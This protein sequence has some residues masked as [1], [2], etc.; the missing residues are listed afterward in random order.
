MKHVTRVLLAILSASPLLRAAAQPV[1]GIA[2][3]VKLYRFLAA[4]FAANRSEF[5]RATFINGL[6][7]FVS[8]ESD[9]EL[10]TTSFDIEEGKIAAI[11]V[12]RN[13]DKLKHLH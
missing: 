4:H 11:Y 10:Q 12:I 9:G 1:I 8:R 13:P 3:V 7:G 5:V 2:S 6:P